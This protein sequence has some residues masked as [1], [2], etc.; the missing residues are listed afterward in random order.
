M[1]NKH[2]YLLALSCGSILC[3]PLV[4]YAIPHARADNLPTSTN[5]TGQIGLNTVP[6]ARMDKS[7]TVR[8]GISTL[9]PYAHSWLGFQLADPLS[10][11]VR[12][13][14]EVSKVNDDAD[15]LY[16][17]VDFKLRLL[18]ESRSRTRHMSKYWDEVK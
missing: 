6:S 14:A 16:P 4:P 1:R 7:G 12:Q 13:S 2:L 3:A 17:G 9:D 5:I 8:A 10:I 11:T 18:T 15:R